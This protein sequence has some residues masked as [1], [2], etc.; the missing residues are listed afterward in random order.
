MVKKQLDTFTV[1]YANVRVEGLKTPCTLFGALM[2][3]GTLENADYATNARSLKSVCAVPF[4]V[5]TILTATDE[6]LSYKHVV[7][8]LFDVDVPAVLTVGEG[9]F[10]LTD[11]K[12]IYTLQIGEYLKNGENLLCFAFT[13][14]ESTAEQSYRDNGFCDRGIF[15]RIE[16]IAYNESF[17][18]SIKCRQVH[19]N[20]KV[21]LHIGAKICGDP[22]GSEVVA[23]LVSPSGRTYYFG[24]HDGE[25]SVLITDPILWW[26]HTLGTP[27]LYRLTLTVYRDGQIVESRSMAIGLRSTALSLADGMGDEEFALTVNGARFFATGAQLC[28]D[29]ALPM[30]DWLGHFEAFIKCCVMANVNL[31]FVTEEIAHLP[32]QF[33]DLCDKHGILVMQDIFAPHDA[34][35]SEE[36]TRNYLEILEQSLSVMCTHP[37]VVL[38]RSHLTGEDSIREIPS[39]LAECAPDAVYTNMFLSK[40]Q[41]VRVADTSRAFPLIDGRASFP[42]IASL[43]R[44]VPENQMN[45]YSETLEA[46]TSTSISEILKEVGERYPY[47]MSMEQLVYATQL[48]QAHRTCEDVRHLRMKRPD[49]MGAILGEASDPFGRVSPSILDRYGVC[50]AVAYALRDAYAPDALIL[51]REGYRVHFYLSNE[52]RDTLSLTLCY[53]LL[54]ASNHLLKEAR[55]EVGAECDTLTPIHSADFSALVHKREHELY[56]HA[57]LLDGETELHSECV[58]FVEPKRFAYQDAKVEASIVEGAGEYTLI[59]T[60]HAFMQSVYLY[61]TDTEAAFENNFFDLTKNAPVRIRFTTRKSN[62]SVDALLEQLHILSVYNIGK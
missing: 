28:P 24:L 15:H 38:L 32:E 21:T 17:I 7:L 55:V 34:A 22:M 27:S 43:R 56:L 37:C 36:A 39:I 35:Q 61:F 50:K 47:A 45:P 6:L 30:D 54:D 23:S 3:V 26:P 20:G 25:G 19:E 14:A 9:R 2:R 42:S 11:E 13:P 60:P 58:L 1:E 5:S 41:S 44:F 46:R 40:G 12:R 57:V 49:A 53:R 48:S 4:T 18:E 51:H 33:Y 59:L 62:L 31:L 29:T 52:R 8:R 10:E 16:V